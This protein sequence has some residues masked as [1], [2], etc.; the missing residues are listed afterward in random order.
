M[1]TTIE[2]DDTLV[3]DALKATGLTLQQEVIELALKTLIQIK[4]QEAI[5]SFRG[6]LPWDGDLESMRTDS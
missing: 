3:I 4:Q 6:Q 2:I 5:R 1:K